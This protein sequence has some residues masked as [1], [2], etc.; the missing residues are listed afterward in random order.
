MEEFLTTNGSTIIVGAI[1]F[2]ALIFVLVR[3]IRN[4]R[5][6]RSACGCSGCNKCTAQTTKTN[7]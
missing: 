4:Y 5:Q 1:V 7:K 2:G 6:G 3:T